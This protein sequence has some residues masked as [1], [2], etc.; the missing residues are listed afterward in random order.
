[1]PMLRAYK[2]TIAAIVGAVLTWGLTAQ[3]DG[4]QAAEWWGLGV[5]V[6]TA[7]GVYQ[8]SNEPNPPDEGGSVEA[9]SLALGLFI[10]LIVGFLFWAGA[11]GR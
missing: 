8:V 6:A 3:D 4:I 7:L 2:K 9:G 11:G 10:G 5:A 1:M